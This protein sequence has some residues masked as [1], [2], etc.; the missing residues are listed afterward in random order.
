[1]VR[2]FYSVSRDVKFGTLPLDDMA[3]AT[4]HAHLL[5]LALA[6]KEILYLSRDC[7][8][9]PTGIF[10]SGCLLRRHSVRQR[11]RTFF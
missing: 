2:I 5:T 6:I 7:H 11:R 10:P 3:T 4:C 8:D 1:M 9:R